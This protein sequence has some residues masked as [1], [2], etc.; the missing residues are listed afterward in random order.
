MNQTIAKWSMLV[1]LTVV[2]LY[3]IAYVITYFKSRQVAKKWI[4][5][6][7]VLSFVVLL[8]LGLFVYVFFLSQ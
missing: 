2:F 4:I 7:L 8:G 1:F 5:V 6:R 3:N